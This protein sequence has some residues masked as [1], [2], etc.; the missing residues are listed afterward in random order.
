MKNNALDNVLI[1]HK[2]LEAKEQLV[3]QQDNPETSINE[4]IDEHEDA[5]YFINQAH[6]E[7]KKLAY[8]LADRKKHSVSRVL[9]A[10]LFEPLERVSL[11]GKHEQ[12]LFAICQQIMYNKGKVLE[13]AFNKHMETIKK[14]ET[15]ERKKE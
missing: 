14:G 2:V 15:N 6:S 7:F 1:D 10:V 4:P 13:Y 5:A 3:K 12:E 9:E 8:A 11:F